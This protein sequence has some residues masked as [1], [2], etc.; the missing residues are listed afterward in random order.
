MGPVNP[1]GVRCETGRRFESTGS[2]ATMVGEAVSRPRREP[3]KGGQLRRRRRKKAKGKAAKRNGTA[4]TGSPRPPSRV[5]GPGPMTSAIVADPHR[6]RKPDGGRAVPGGRIRWA[7]ETGT[8]GRRPRGPID[9]ADRGT[10]PTATDDAEGSRNDPEDDGV[11]TDRPRPPSTGGRWARSNDRPPRCGAVV[12]A[13]LAVA[14]ALSL[15]ALSNQD[16]LGSSRTSA[17]AAARTDAVQLASYD[18]RDLG[19]DFGAVVAKSTPSFRRR[20]TESSDALKSTL[21]KYKATAEASVVSAGLV[22]ASTSRAVA[23]VFSTRRS[24][25][26]R[27][28]SRPPI[29][30]RSRSPW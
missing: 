19:R 29:G 14:L 16:A 10:V 27:R 28:P 21:T 4:R 22:S 5:D 11:R 7:N 26:R 30:A 12:V 6:G 9:P 25:T 17:L 3:T 20:F 24:P 23:L 2:V 18:Y 1:R 15:L 13:A 8:P